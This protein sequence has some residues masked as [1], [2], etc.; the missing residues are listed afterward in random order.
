MVSRS[1]DGLF[2]F[3]CQR[4]G[5]VQKAQ[6]QVVPKKW[7][8]LTTF[9]EE[10]AKYYYCGPCKELILAP[11]LVRYIPMTQENVDRERRLWQSPT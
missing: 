5:T 11:C 4:C 7:A 2:H 8:V 1:E 6:A 3:E 9:N 10:S